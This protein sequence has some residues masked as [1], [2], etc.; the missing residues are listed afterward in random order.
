MKTLRITLKDW[1]HTCGDGCCYDYGQDIYLDGEK[2][3]EQHAEDSENAL[4]AVL[5]KLGYKIEIENIYEDL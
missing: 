3:D 1:E 5:E 4:R 2:L